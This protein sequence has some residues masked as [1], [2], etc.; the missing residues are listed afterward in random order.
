MGPPC[1]LNRR[2]HEIFLLLRSLII[3]LLLIYLLL[4]IAKTTSKEKILETV[5]FL[6]ERPYLVENENCTPPESLHPDE[7]LFPMIYVITPTYRRP[8]QIPLLVQLSHTLLQVKNISWL[9]VEDA[10]KKSKSVAEFLQKCGIH[11]QHLIGPMPE[12]YRKKKEQPKGVSNRNRAIQWLKDH[13][14]SG[15]MYFADDDNT[16]DVQL[17]EEMRYTRRV[18]MWPVGLCSKFGWSS[19]IVKEGCLVGFYD[20]W[21]GY[22]KYPVDMA[23]FAVNIDFMKKHPHAYVPYSQGYEEDGFLKSLESL[24][25]T[26]IEVKASNCT[27]ILVWHTQ[28]KKFNS[29]TDLDEK[30]YGDTNLLHLKDQMI[31]QGLQ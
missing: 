5:P 25:V 17:F 15:V 2:H 20:S 8:E 9:V 4:K 26:D 28:I 19:P 18:S 3:I 1:G 7:G 24:K 10:E 29:W 21:I 11:Y 31:S 13:N 6:K 16:Y 22:R 27:K 12:K 30:L 14:T 23:G